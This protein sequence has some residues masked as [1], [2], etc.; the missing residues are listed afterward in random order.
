MTNNFVRHLHQAYRRSSRAHRC[1]HCGATIPT[2]EIHNL[3]MNQ[4]E[5]GVYSI[6]EHVSCLELAGF[7][8]LAMD[9]TDEGDGMPSIRTMW[10]DLG[11]EQMV[12]M[13]DADMFSEVQGLMV[14]TQEEYD[15]S[16]S[17]TGKMSE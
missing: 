3:Q 1:L 11:P 5:R 2:G 17:E 16:R 14:R 13:I 7:L 12:T 15:L 8:W 4:Y 9:V 6:R 10:E